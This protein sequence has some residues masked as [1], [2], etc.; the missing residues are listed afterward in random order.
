M[1]KSE[2]LKELKL[3]EKKILKQM[4]IG[5]KWLEKSSKLLGTNH[6]LQENFSN[7]K[8]DTNNNLTEVLQHHLKN[9]D[10]VVKCL[11]EVRKNKKLVD[12]LSQM[13]QDKHKIQLIEN[14]IN[15]LNNGKLMNEGNNKHLY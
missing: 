10:I 12:V 1:S 6:N 5:L 7:I 13:G 3:L 14:S 8:I 4:D 15:N 11:N 9:D 2:K